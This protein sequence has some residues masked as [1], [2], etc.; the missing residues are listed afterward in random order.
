MLAHFPQPGYLCLALPL[1]CSPR[2][3]CLRSSLME[4]E[5]AREMHWYRLLCSTRMALQCRGDVNQLCVPF[6]RGH[7]W[8]WLASIQG[9]QV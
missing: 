8:K 9:S 5:G 1:P 6:W 4:S 7:G 3:P 2:V